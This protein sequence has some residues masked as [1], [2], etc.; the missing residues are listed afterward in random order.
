[1]NDKKIFFIG[2]GLIG[3]SVAKGLRMLYPGA[4]ITAWTRHRDRIEAA[5]SDGTLN[6]IETDMIKAASDADVIY[7]CAPTVR[8]IENLRAIA[9]HIRPDALITDV[10]SVKSDISACAEELKL[11]KQFLGGH[12]MCG[13]EKVGYEYADAALLKNAYY[14]LTPSKETEQ[15]HIDMMTSVVK[16]LGAIPK[17]AD[18]AY[19]DLAAAAISHVPHLAAAGLVELVRSNDNGDGFMRTIA[20]GGFKDTTRIASSDPA[21]WENI[22]RSNT[23]S[24]HLMLR[25]LIDIL[26]N[27][28]KDLIEGNFDRINAL[29]AENGPYRLTM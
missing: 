8:N 14:I 6:D 25:K 20:A 16:A 5:V 7:L 12:P 4:R 1:M 22:C 2:L 9:P 17:L 18:P 13:K 23:E 10:G 28:D 21:M 15:R 19:H 26:E 24:I 27:T 11:S 29:F 3:G